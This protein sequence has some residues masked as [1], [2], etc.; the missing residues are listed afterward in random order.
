MNTKVIANR[1]IAQDYF[2]LDFTWD[3][4]A[5]IPKPGQFITIR[6]T[7]GTVPLLR[8]PFAFSGYDEETHTGSIIYLKRGTGTE[9]LTRVIPGESIDIIGPLGN[10]LKDSGYEEKP[11]LIAGGIGLGPILFYSAMLSRSGTPHTFI[12]GARSSEAVPQIDL[13]K[14][15][16]SHTCDNCICTDD[17]T[18]GFPGT[19]IDLLRTF[20]KHVLSGSA[21]YCCGPTPMLKGC[22]EFALLHNL[23]CYVV[24]EQIMACG[25]GACMGCTIKVKGKSGFARVCMEGPVFESRDIVWT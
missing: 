16:D 11:V 14:A 10:Y 22:H 2:K 13:L 15:S 1:E 7:A 25:V 21:L 3:P 4:D 23:N 19:V 5:G 8:R 9:L 6:V 18:T 12:F 24:M 17:G 20:P